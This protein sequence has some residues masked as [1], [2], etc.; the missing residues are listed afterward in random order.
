[1]RR[2]IFVFSVGNEQKQ[3]VKEQNSII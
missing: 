2:D 1:M 3:L